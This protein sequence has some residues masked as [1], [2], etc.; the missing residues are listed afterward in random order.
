MKYNY[1][2]RSTRE[3][4]V[5]PLGIGGA[6]P[7]R[8]QSMTNTST[9]DTEASALQ[10]V[11]IAE[12]GGELVRLT[13]QGVAEA[14]NMKA[15]KERMRELGC[16]V[17]VSADVHFNPQAAFVA[18]ETSD[19]VR[20]NPGNFVD[21]A[22]TFRHLDF[23]DEEYAEEIGR[24]RAK[25]IPFLDICRKNHTAVRLGVNHG[26]LSDRI[27]SRYGNTAPGMVE[28]VMEFLRICREVDFN[29]IVISVKASNTLVMVETVRLLVAEME[30]EGMDFP[31]HL[32]VTEAGA[33]D[34]GRI[35]SAV[36]I[37]ALMFDGLGDTIRVS[38]SEAPEAEI[39]VAALLRD[40]VARAA[41]APHVEEP[42]KV[43][44][45]DARDYARASLAAHPMG[46]KA[47]FA[48]TLEGN[49][50]LAAADKG[51]FEVIA[52]P[53]GHGNAPGWIAAEIDRRVAS[54]SRAAM[55][56]EISYDC[57]DI[58]ELRVRAGADFGA[59]LLSGYGAA[60]HIVDPHFPAD[61]L[62]QMELDILQAARMRFTKTEFISCPSCGRTLFDLPAALSEVKA[63][64]SK[65]GMPDLKIAVMGCIVNG[66]GEMADA[67]YGYVGA[68]PGRVSIYRNKELVIK[69]IPTA[70]ALPA[71]LALIQSDRQ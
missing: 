66:P 12:A 61:V 2:R 51:V 71:L 58:D 46:A 70:E 52:A 34:D 9:R 57:S 25:L 40:H 41:G 20:I 1:N 18:A 30:K 10:A 50:A 44:P 21:A 24:I 28:S 27:M 62:S 54:G 59:L 48:W 8:L 22:R 16:T 6:N 65:L 26:S 36:G 64:V 39:P 45:G 23:T 13:T 33:G 63:A 3:V 35:K 37:G 43:L 68:G 14:S 69:N 32:G 56:M 49:D 17:P 47:P 31:L 15:I 38:L 7:V 4:M 55:V 60:I 19:K 42:E 11:R 29:D 5:G 67:D 53:A